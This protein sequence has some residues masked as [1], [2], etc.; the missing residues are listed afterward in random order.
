MIALNI[1]LLIL[2]LA[3][4]VWS[5]R[6]CRRKNA[7]L[8]GSRETAR[9]SAEVSDIILKNVHAYVLLITDD[10][11]VRK[12]NYYELTG[13]TEP[14]TP[15]R[16][17]NMLRCR[18]GEDAGACG[19]Y[20]LC[21]DCPVRAAINR[22][23]V[24]KEGFYDLK[25]VMVVYASADKS[26]T[27]SCEMS[28]TGVYLP[29]NGAPYLLLTVFDITKRKQAELELKKAKEKA[30]E[31]E[32]IK[33]TFLANMSHEIRTPLNAIVGFSDMLI[34]AEKPEEK[35]VY[36]R[37][38]EN[39]MSQLLHLMQNVLDLSR[40]ENDLEEFVRSNVELNALLQDIADFRLQKIPRGG[41]RLVFEPSLPVCYVHIEV[42]HLVR[43]IRNLLVNALKF[44]EKGTVTFGYRIEGRELCFYVTDTGCG[45]PAEKQSAI[46]DRFVKLRD[47]GPGTGLGLSICQEIVRRMDG[48]IGVVSEEGKG[49]T[50]W[51]RVPYYPGNPPGA[52]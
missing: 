2:L 47:H 52:C 17:G 32:K 30:E 43:V 12:T 51:F 49:S 9:V 16:V 50:F 7:A 36:V 14:E 10:F 34:S 37:L 45:I 40:I 5:Y 20:D 4:F 19:S 26:R 39:N 11:L 46:F 48:T 15:E 29:I 6:N 27:L 1:I 42:S 24:T 8:A 18:N 3:L 28:V 31:S 22:T 44:T 41:V 38:I 13:V 33:S 25:V 35:Q 23:F 21:V